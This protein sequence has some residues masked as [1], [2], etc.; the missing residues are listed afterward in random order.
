[1]HLF[2][3]VSYGVHVDG[4]LHMGSCVVIGDLRAVP[5]RSS[6][7]QIVSKSSTEAEPIAIPTELPHTAGIRHVVCDNLS[8]Q[9]Q[10]HGA[11]CAGQIGR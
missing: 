9:P 7:E 1:V 2:V 5:C 3:Y 10:L 4:L 6:K 11:T 8:G